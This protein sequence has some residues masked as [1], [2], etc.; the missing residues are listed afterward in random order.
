MKSKVNL[1]NLRIH[2]RFCTHHSTKD[3][4]WGGVD[5]DNRLATD[6]ELARR[7]GRPAGSTDE[8]T[9]IIHHPIN[10][11]HYLHN[12]KC[13]RCYDDQVPVSWHNVWKFA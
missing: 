2:V 7:R 11:F 13:D 12:L 6:E 9:T 1:Y 4:V 10:S 3:F 8:S 5:E